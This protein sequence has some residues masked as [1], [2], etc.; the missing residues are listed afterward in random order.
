MIVR[1]DVLLE[2]PVAQPSSG[3]SA[4]VAVKQ[5]SQEQEGGGD[6]Q[7]PTRQ[8]E[9]ASERKPTLTLHGIW[10]EPIS[11]QPGKEGEPE[12]ADGG[13]RPAADR[14]EQADGAVATMIHVIPSAAWQESSF[15]GRR[16]GRPGQE[17]FASA[18]RRTTPCHFTD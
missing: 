7:V 4:D 1:T 8:L 2:T 16:D 3:G 15:S 5:A 17:D 6:E 14:E 9:I 10:A 11:Q 12:K 13:A 18:T